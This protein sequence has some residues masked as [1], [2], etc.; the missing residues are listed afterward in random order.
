MQHNIVMRVVVLCLVGL[1]GGALA[2]M[3]SSATAATGTWVSPAWVAQG[4]YGGILRTVDQ[5]EPDHWDLH[6]SCCNPGPGAARD[7]FNTLVMYNPAQPDE[8]IGDLAQHWDVSPDGMRYTFYLHEAQWWDG[9]PVTAADVQFSL[10]RM[11][12]KGKPRPRVGALRLYVER[13]EVV[14]PKTVRVHTKFPTPVA[15]LPWLAMDYAVIYPKHV[16]E[17]GVD[18]DDPKLIVG[19]GPFRFKSYQRGQSWE[20]VKNPTYFKKGLPFLDGIQAF[21]IKDA[22]RNIAA[23]QAGQVL[24]CNRISTCSL[25]VKDFLELERVMQGKGTLYWQGPTNPTGLNLNF[26]KPPFNDPR[27]RRAVYLAIDRQ[28][29]IQVAVLGRGTVG[30]PFFPNTW[31]SSPLEAVMTW[32]GFRQ[33][34]DADLAQAKQLLAE[35]GYA[36]GF[37]TTFLAYPQIESMALLI[38]Q[39]LKKIGIEIELKVVDVNTVLAAQAQGDYTLTGIRHGPS[40]IDPDEVFQAMYLPGGPRNQLRW[41]DPK[42]TELFEQQTRES[43]P[44]RRRRLIAEAETRIRQGETGWMTLFW[45]ADFANMVSQRVTNFHT[46]QTLHTV[47]THEHLWLDAK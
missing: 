15:L 21:V 17:T 4:K 19:S 45:A 3:P 12:E 32:P 8:I 1:V 30:T 9:Q 38:K 47:N 11:I 46:P 14:D 24:M 28:E 5:L 37:K 10:H 13:T 44:A 39:Q 7:L 6:Q 33:P 40:I 22:T 31:M 42:L 2:A 18:F 27:V 23:F 25:N 35:A 36:D 26:T 41:E 34:K 43:D 20:V 16:L 29:L